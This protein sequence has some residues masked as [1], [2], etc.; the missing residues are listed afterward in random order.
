MRIRQFSQLWPQC[1]PNRPIKAPPT[2]HT[3]TSYLLG[4]SP[5]VQLSAADILA[6]M[7]TLATRGENHA[8]RAHIS[9]NTWAMLYHAMR[10]AA[11]WGTGQK[12]DPKDHYELALKTGTTAHGQTYQSWA[13][14]FF[15]ADNPH[16][17]FCT[18][19]FRGTSE[20]SA[21]PALRTALGKYFHAT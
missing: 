7:R 12:A 5:E 21:I 1:F 16:Y 15:P 13:A 10:S 8:L 11:R 17:I 4:Y 19:A 18:R 3:L 20:A 14:G 6:W 9:P 2:Y